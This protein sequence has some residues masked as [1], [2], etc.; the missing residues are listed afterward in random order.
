[1]RP[2]TFAAWLDHARSTEARE[3]CGLVVVRDGVESYLPCRNIHP[4]PEKAF[5]LDAAELIAA[6]QCGEITAYC[7]SHPR[8]G[9]APSDADRTGCEAS[10][11]PWLIIHPESGEWARIDPEGYEAPLVGRQWCYG[12]LD[13][14]T[15]AQDW[16]RRERGITLHDFPRNGYWWERG[17]DRY[18]EILPAAGFGLVDQPEDG[19]ILLFQVGGKAKTPNHIGIYLGGEVLH[20]LQDRLSS[21]DLFGGYWLE[22]HVSTYRYRGTN[23]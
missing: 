4:A 2:E 21:R 8:L 23:G 6:E 20:H 18:R 17:E 14:A 3:S 16:Y 19:D 5:L 13:C 10:G 12:V 22:K 15:L 11:K 1:M 7:H 9:P